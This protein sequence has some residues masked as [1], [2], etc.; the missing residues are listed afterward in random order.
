MGPKHTSQLT[1]TAH[2]QR[3]GSLR[4]TML[5][6]KEDRGLYEHDKRM[7]Y[8]STGVGGV[9]PFRFGVPPTITVITL[10]TAR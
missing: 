5:K 8:V 3:S 10:H 4:P 7:L 9:L 1:C 6:Y 2:A